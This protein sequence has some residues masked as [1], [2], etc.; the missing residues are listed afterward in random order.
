MN[1][2]FKIILIGLL[3]LAFTACS[4]QVEETEELVYTV[5]LHHAQLET[6]AM[7]LGAVKFKELVEA[8]TNGKVIIDIFPNAQLGTDTEAAEYIQ[9]GSVQAGIIP[10]AKLSGFHAPIQILDLPFL[11]P[12]REALYGT[13]DNPEFLAAIFT[14]MEDVGFKGIN[15]WES[16]FKQ[17]TAN[18][19]IHSPADFV[20]LKF[21]TMESP[22][23]IAQFQI[24]GAN[25]VPIDFAETYN[26]LQQKVV[27]GQ[28][29]PVVSIKNM[30]FYEVQTNMIVSN[31]AYLGYAF[32]FGNEFWKTLPKE[33]QDIIMNASKVAVDYERQLSIDSEAIMIKEIADSGTVV[34]YLTDAETAVFSEVMKPVHEQFRSVLGSDLLDLTYSTIKSFE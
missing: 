27:D 24:L 4:P 22:L 10:T 17:L 14:P 11:F 26:A 7:H 21:R 16:G 9:T 33:Y 13:M 23:I 8:E 18:K 30:K 5:K 28:E 32:L 3:I 12:T 20:G 34:T 19:E 31:H 15:I 25:P 2:L 6:T 1:K 29:N